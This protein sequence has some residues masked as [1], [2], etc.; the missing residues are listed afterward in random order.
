MD[1]LF[2]ITPNT[3]K[4]YR[5]ILVASFCALVVYGSF[6]HWLIA[7]F[8]FFIRC[9]L[10]TAVIHRGISHR[11]FKMHKWIEYPLAAISLSGTTNSVISWASIHREHH[12]HSDTDLDPHCPKE[13]FFDVQTLNFKK[14]VNPMYGVDLIKDPFYVWLHRWHWAVT[15]SV[16]IILFFIEPLSILY[17]W[18]VP[19]CLQAYAGGTVNALNHIK[20]GYRNFNTNDNSYNNLITGYLCCGEGWHNN[21]HQDPKNPK[22]GFKWWE[23]DPGY[24]LT[25]LIGIKD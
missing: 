4:I 9:L 6:F 19:A 3:V 13:S 7:I 1:Y 16:A 2:R 5:Y 18:L 15:I 12:R 10:G 23:F 25:K 8:V 20:F 17:V 11:A 21:H 22:F 24:Y 14:S